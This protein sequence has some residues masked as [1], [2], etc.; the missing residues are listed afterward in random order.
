MGHVRRRNEKVPRK[1]SCLAS[2]IF[3]ITMPGPSAPEVN[4]S[5]SK[6]KKDVLF[7][8]VPKIEDE[9]CLRAT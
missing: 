9:P 2:D 4:V 8:Q 1:L 7:V 6:R 3:N 5:R